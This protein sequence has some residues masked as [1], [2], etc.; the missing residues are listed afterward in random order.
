MPITTT[1]TTAV[2][3]SPDTLVQTQVDGWTPG[4]MIALAVA[5]ATFVG[6]M[7][8]QHRELVTAGNS[9]VKLE[10]LADENEERISALERSTSTEK[11][12][13]LAEDNRK[14][15]AVLE[16]K[17]NSKESR[18]VALEK[19]V[20]HIKESQDRVE[21]MMR[22]DFKDFRDGLND[23]RAAVVQK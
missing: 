15:I 17:D 10:E 18:L 9:I 13:E 11:T 4:V 1:S 19:D 5:A 2:P 8:K 6:W 23:I 3:D 7:F 21:R 20:S 16:H 22:E 14:R 12:A